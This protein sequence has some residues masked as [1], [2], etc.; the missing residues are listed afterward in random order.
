MN[1]TL[2]EVRWSRKTGECTRWET[3]DGKSSITKDEFGY[4]VNAN[5]NPERA[6]TLEKA[7]SIVNSERYY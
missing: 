2:N 4:S 7:V 1:V 5:G 3:A 6:I